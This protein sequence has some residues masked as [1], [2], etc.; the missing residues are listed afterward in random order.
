MPN[1]FTS[2]RNQNLVFAFA[3][4]LVI[5][6]KIITVWHY[7][8]QQMG[9][10]GTYI[11]T[12]DIILSGGDWLSDAGLNNQTHPP[13]LSRP[14]GYSF[15]IAG[16]KAL[17]NE[18]W[19]VA[20]CALQAFLSLLTG[21]L[22][23]QLCRKAKIPII[24]STIVFLF[25]EWSVPLSTDALI[26]EDAL[27]GT[28][29][30]ASFLIFLFPIVQNQI[31][32]TKTFLL[33]GVMTAITFLIRDIYH[34]VMPIV[35]MITFIILTKKQNLK[36]GLAAA[37]ALVVPVLL[38]SALIHGWNYH[39]IGTPVSTTVGQ[40]AYLFG[41]IRAARFDETILDGD[42]IY[43]KT[44][45]KNNK[46][47]Q[48]DDV[49]RINNILFNEYGMNS[50]EQSRAASRLFWGTL[51]T[52]PVPMIK[53]SFARVR[54]IQQGTLFSGPVTR[55]DDLHWW[56]GNIMH[57]AFYASGW[58]AEAQKFRETLDPSTLTPRVFFH[59]S[60]RTI[61]RIIGVL[62]LAIFI[63][64]APWLWLKKREQLGGIAHAALISWGT[65]VL[66]VC[67]YIPVSFEVRYLSPLIGTAMMTIAIILLNYRG[68][69]P[70]NI[71][72]KKQ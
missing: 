28:L 17:F 45:R 72:S 44:I 5:V 23:F 19:P 61:V 57:K 47:F 46:T 35:A 66:W 4:F 22:L 32:T 10:N 7:G 16:V 39:R 1:L 29:G 37:C 50:L 69:V 43:M 52:N 20:L 68:L 49:G 71:F 3:L 24:Y 41:V 36:K 64:G 21:L 30:M 60:L 25:Y 62:A 51:F 11:K 13:T 54:L 40:S 53:A 34:F 70:H 9:D 2:S 65:Y 56:S 38:M 48:F 33:V 55:L 15:A 6:G 12:A 67:M 42:S 18:N 63:I 59:L 58:R 14:L 8:P 31:P 27:M 26:M